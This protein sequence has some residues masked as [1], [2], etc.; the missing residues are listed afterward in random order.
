MAKHGGT[1]LAAR[2]AL[3]VA[4]LALAALLGVA[5]PAGA[6]AGT[7]V[8]VVGAADRRSHDPGKG[9]HP[10]P[11]HTPTGDPTPVP[12]DPPTSDP[13]ATP[14]DTPTLT[15]TA[16]DPGGQPP[17][18]PG[19]KGSTDP[20]TVPGVV[21][22]ANNPN[23]PDQKDPQPANDGSVI[24]G[25]QIPSSAPDGQQS[26][27]VPAVAPALGASDTVRLAG[28]AMPLWLIVA[29][30]ALLVIMI[31]VGLALT[32][33]D[34]DTEPATDGLTIFEGPETPAGVKFG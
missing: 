6:H 23:N 26:A 4:V 32:L 14:P 17:P 2:T 3:G 16:T 10:T 8:P 30:G 22:V 34:R 24:L 28:T 25:R 5:L 27:S 7:V 12:T 21:P 11:S 15:Q 20:A 29:T 13:P 1:R 9:P 19:P 33:R 18:Q 31:A